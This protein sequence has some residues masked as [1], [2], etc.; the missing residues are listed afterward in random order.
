[1]QINMGRIQREEN[2]NGKKYSRHEKKLC[3]ADCSLG[4]TI[5]S[6]ALL[7]KQWMNHPMNLT[8]TYNPSTTPLGAHNQ[9]YKCHNIPC[10]ART[11]TC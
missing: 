9:Q 5:P 7:K 6:E 4:P 1:M 11:V 3:Q 2:E 8:Y 10:C